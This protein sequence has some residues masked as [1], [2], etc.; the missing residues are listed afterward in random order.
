MVG[1]ALV[2]D[3][4][5]F[6]EVG[7]RGLVHRGGALHA[8]IHRQVAD[9]VLVQRQRQLFLQRQRVEFAG[10]F[11]RRLH[12]PRRHAMAREVKEANPFARVAHLRGGGGGVPGRGTDSP[13]VARIF[14]PTSRLKATI[15]GDSRWGRTWRRRLTGSVAPSARAAST[16]SR[17]RS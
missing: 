4:E 6:V 17:S 11:E 14:A 8:L 5:A 7:P 13:A 12:D 16:N 10:C 1:R 3:E 9:V 2:T 15:T